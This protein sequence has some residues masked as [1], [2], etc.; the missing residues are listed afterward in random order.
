MRQHIA[1]ALVFLILNTFCTAEENG[2]LVTNGGFENGV[3]GWGWEQWRGRVE[4]GHLD[5]ADTHNG[6]S[7]YRMTL[8]GEP[9]M[10]FIN[11]SARNID[12]G[13]D[14][15]FSIALCCDNMPEN[16]AIVRILQYGEGAQGWVEAV[17]GSGV[18]E[19]VTTG[20]THDWKEFGVRIPAKSI[21]PDT[22][23]FSI[24]IY[25]ELAGV[26]VLGVDDVSLT[27]VATVD[28]GE[29]TKE[30]KEEAQ[31]QKP[32]QEMD[33]PDTNLLPGDTSYETGSCGWKGIVD[34][35]TS[36]YGNQSLLLSE[37]SQE[38]R[39]SKYY[40]MIEP[41]RSYTLSFYAR[42]D[43]P[44]LDIIVDVWHLRYSIMKRQN[45]SLSD[46]WKRYFMEIPPQDQMRGFY[47][48]IEKKGSGAIWL[49]GL[50]FQAGK[51]TDYH[52]SEPISVAIGDIPEPNNILLVREKPVEL[53]VGIYNSDYPAESFIFSYT[54]SDFYGKVVAEGTEEIVVHRDSSTKK[55]VTA[56]ENRRNGYFVTNVSIRSGD[57]EIIKQDEMPYGIVYPQDVDG[58][59][60]DSYFGLH[61][62]ISIEARHRIGAKW[63]R[64]YRAWRWLE[65]EKG[66]FSP[67]RSEYEKYRDAGI[68][69]METVNYDPMPDWA[70]DEDGKIRDIEEYCDFAR[71][72][73][74]QADGYVTYWEIQNE[75]DL[76]L[77]SVRN[78]S[79]EEKA[80]YYADILKAASAA[81]KEADPQAVIMGSGV[82]GVDVPDFEFSREVFRQ[83]SEYFDVFALH[84]Y[85]GVRFIGTE[86]L[87]IGPEE[88]MM[89]EAMVKAVQLVHE[90]GG[91]HAIWVGEFGW[92]L[93]LKEPYLGRYARQYAQ[94]ITRAIILTHSVP[95]VER[96][97]WFY[98]RGCLERGHFEYG[99]WRGEEEPLSAAVA[100]AATARTLHGFKAVRPIFESDVRAYVF[101]KGNIPLVAMWKWQGEAVDMLLDVRPEDVKIID[102]IGNRVEPVIEGDR[103]VVNLSED[104]VFVIGEGM[105][106][107]R[108]YKKVEES[109]FSGVP[110][111]I[112]VLHTDG[113]SLNGFV[114]NNWPYRVKGIL[115]ISG[116]S[117]ID[118]E[119]EASSIE[120]FS[121]PL[122]RENAVTLVGEFD[123]IGIEKEMD[124]IFDTCLRKSI[125]LNKDGDLSEW[126]KLPEIVLSESPKVKAY[127]AWDED[128]FYLAAG[129]QDS[130]FDVD[131]L[132]LAFDTMN[133]SLEKY[134]SNDYEFA[135]TL[136]KDGAR[137]LSRFDPE[138]TSNGNYR[139]NIKTVIY[140]ND[141]R[142]TY[143]V[144]IPWKEI[145]PLKPVIGRMFGFNLI[146]SGKN[147]NVEFSPKYP[148]TFKKIVLNE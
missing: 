103:I 110:V 4:P 102:M 143:Q 42:T 142:M 96:I 15:E 1:T 115:G 123:D 45:F 70:K 64:N 148:R 84:P 59:D 76:S 41:G 10:R 116:S 56:L 28:E 39:S 130:N 17:P 16:A 58:A 112:S 63:M 52:P 109:S 125:K 118:M 8:P 79:K 122:N 105:E 87:Y 117:A 7:C 54:T 6:R 134:D 68:C 35:T 62:G 55:R 121:F 119:L 83:A 99:L 75:P 95:E 34:P 27:H 126:E 104:P 43:K 89:R 14:Y 67:M 65:Q 144:A 47:I 26:G 61:G 131:S 74:R 38:H 53:E 5:N 120:S 20:G 127:S 51:L 13:S 44:R 108:L 11:V 18:S 137:V 140:N 81:I 85:M 135:A 66:K 77:G 72:L 86:G 132:E 12:P 98:G 145:S 113:K 36:A 146:V 141:D 94:Y 3:K 9:G 91:K 73:V 90:F 114:K 25:H 23:R 124:M 101:E 30:P 136:T 133:D 138:G 97:M 60:P 100:Y 29:S 50:Q 69:L 106:P 33:I 19:L 32:Q 21:K 129:A 40:E 111:R 49:D 71:E 2:N 88:G 31:P 37:E 78:L 22:N 128:Y 82:S 48:A 139:D 24:F 93:D 147:D 80:R 107:A 57:G 46:E 92:A